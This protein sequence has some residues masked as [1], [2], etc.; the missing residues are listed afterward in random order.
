MLRWTRI[1]IIVQHQDQRQYQ[2]QQ[3]HNHPEEEGQHN[4]KHLV[5]ITSQLINVLENSLGKPAV[6]VCID[7]E[8]HVEHTPDLKKEQINPLS[9]L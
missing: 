9:S 3:Q 4:K 1:G 7:E 8:L 2:G 6:C 5:K